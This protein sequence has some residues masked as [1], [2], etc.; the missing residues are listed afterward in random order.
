VNKL[1]RI[2]LPSHSTPNHANPQFYTINQST[3]LYKIFRLKYCPTAV[4]FRFWG[5]HSRFDHHRGN[6]PGVDYEPLNCEPCEDSERGISYVAPKFSSCLVEVFGD[7]PEAAQITHEYQFAILTPKTDLKLLDIRDSGAMLAGA[8][9]ASLAKSEKRPVT[10]VWSR[11]FYEQQETYT[12]VQGII[13]RNAHN[14]E[15]AISFYERA[16]HLLT[17]LPEDTFPLGSP[18]LRSYILRAAKDN[19]IRVIFPEWSEL[20]NLHD[21]QKMTRTYAKANK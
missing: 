1:V 5:P 4:S 21:F 6:P 15:E 9:E 13:Y 11:Y 10:Q 12:E 20:T 14:N 19:N 16:Q 17:C 3:K 18:H 7:T 2:I 8:N